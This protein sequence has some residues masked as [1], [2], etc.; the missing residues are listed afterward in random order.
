LEKTV[1]DIV[2]VITDKNHE[3]TEKN[4][5]IPENRRLK[6]TPITIPDSKKI[7]RDQE[8]QKRNNPY[9]GFNTDINTMIKTG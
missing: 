5:L 3:R 1:N 4:L 6:P 7:Y 9:P 2:K 8:D